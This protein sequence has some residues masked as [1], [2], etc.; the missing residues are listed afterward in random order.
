M[1][2]GVPLRCWRRG[3][4]QASDRKARNQFGQLIHEWPV[5]GDVERL[6]REQLAASDNAALARQPDGDAKHSPLRC[7]GGKKLA[8]DIGCSRQ[9]RGRIGCEEFTKD[10]GG[11]RS[12]RCQTLGLATRSARP[13]RS[14]QLSAAMANVS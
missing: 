6:L 2:L 12:N 1:G 3:M 9:I 7:V 13:I 5:D 14:T 4:R 11:M 10:L 8:H